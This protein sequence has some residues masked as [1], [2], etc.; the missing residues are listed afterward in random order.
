MSLKNSIKLKENGENCN[1]PFFSRPYFPLG[2]VHSRVA[3]SFLVNK[4]LITYLKIWFCRRERFTEPHP[5]P[6]LSFSL[7]DK[8]C[9][10]DELDHF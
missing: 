7:I 1:F 8:N 5:L 9:F 4:I 6:L 10:P 3:L 2:F